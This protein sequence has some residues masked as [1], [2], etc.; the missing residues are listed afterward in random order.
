[1]VIYISLA[2]ALLL[3]CVVLYARLA[4]NKSANAENMR[5]ELTRQ[6]NDLFQEKSQMQNK[7]EDYIERG[8][9]SQAQI[10][11]LGD[12]NYKLEHELS[13]LKETNQN[14]Q[15]ELFQAKKA[16]ELKIQAMAEVEKRM[17]DWEAAR[18]EA[19]NHAKAAIFEAGSKLSNQLLEQHKTETKE[20]QTKIAQTTS[21]LQTQFEKILN[22][23]AVMDGEIKSSKQ[24]VEIVRNSLL[25]PA[26]AGGLAEIA[27]E[28]IL[29]AS[30][31]E[32]GRDFIMQYS[33]NAAGEHNKLRPDAVVFLPADCVL[34]IDSK[35]SKFFTELAQTED[36]TERKLILAQLKTTMR[37]H[38]KALNSKDYKEALRQHLKD[39]KP[40]HISSVMFL[41]SES[42]VETLSG[43]DK[44][45][46]TTAWEQEIFPAGPTGLVNIL[47]Q[48]KFQ[49]GVARQAHNQHVII[50][51]VRKLLSSFVILSDYAKKIGNSLQSATSNYDKF[52]GS[53]NS[54]LLP[55]ARNL[56]KLG[57]HLQKNKSLPT[58]LER[59]TV[60]SSDKMALI[61]VED[62]TEE[63]GKADAEE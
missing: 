11:S 26:G 36:E 37:N 43:I 12:R 20:S 51:E 4:S 16:L 38:L 6:L 23:V 31:L 48:A 1:M 42:A 59:L 56:E 41:P 18:F 55:K 24:T 40:Q 47:S 28:N 63:E 13:T 61:D 17:S 34:V 62:Y 54:K 49:I 2:L 21:E 44:E 33:L 22:T 39:S 9:K 53:F 3:L 52:A 10:D 15:Q 50:E 30:G 25:T 46:M 19:I 35:A 57:I 5:I 32:P 7:L 8:G 45:F 58:S 14:L 27:L 60:I 29:K